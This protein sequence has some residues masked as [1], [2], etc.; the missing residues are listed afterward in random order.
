MLDAV[1][2]GPAVGSA[3][4]AALLA[5]EALL[6]PAPS[7][8]RGSTCTARSESVA[9]ASARCCSAPSASCGWRARST[10]YGATRGDDRHAAPTSSSRAIRSCRS[11]RCSCWCSTSPSCA[12]CRSTRSPA[13]R[14]TRRRRVMQH[15][16]R[17]RVRAGGPPPGA[18]ARHPAAR[19]ARVRRPHEPA[20][21]RRGRQRGARAARGGH[22]AAA[23]RGR[24]RRP[25]RPLGASSSSAGFGL[26]EDIVVDPEQATGLTRRRRGPG[27]DRSFITYLG[28]TGTA[29]A[30]IVPPSSLA[31]DQCSCATTSARRR[32][33]GSRP[34]GC[35]QSARELGRADVLRHG[36]GHGR[37]HGRHAR[38]D[39]RDPAARGRV[40]AQ[41]GRGPR[42][43]AGTDSVDQGRPGAAAALGRLGRD[44]ARRGRLHRRSG[45]TAGAWRSPAPRDR[46]D[47]HHRR[48]RCLQRRPGVRTASGRDWPDALSAATGLASSLVARPSNDRHTVRR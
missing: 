32:C 42:A 6:L 17:H 40:P 16:H 1:G 7:T 3:G 46:A 24:R 22:D 45:R 25:L 14:T 11:S 29:S 2:A 23:G 47:G 21:R 48:G 27:R 41:R 31:T 44:Q 5:R 35:S 10:G 4:E 13:S 30:E 19:Y 43:S 34:A 9:T 33:G 18:R 28:V 8:R 20:R 39:A 15:R 12:A 26:G 38:G 36:L 37:L